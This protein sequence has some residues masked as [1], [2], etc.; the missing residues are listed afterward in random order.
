MI[1]EYPTLTKLRRGEV[2]ELGGMLF[3][4]DEGDLKP[5]DLYIAERNGS[6]K[7][8][9]V[10]RVDLDYGTVVPTTPEYCFDLGECIKIKETK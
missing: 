3:K 8:L 7:L 6:P 9:E 10:K 5:G 2:V 1:R 4:K